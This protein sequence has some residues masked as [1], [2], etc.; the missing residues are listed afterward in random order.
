MANLKTKL[1]QLEQKAI[2]AMMNPHF[3]FNVI[4]AIQHFIN[5]GDKIAANK[6]LTDFAKLIRMSNRFSGRSMVLIEEEIAYLLL[7]LSF[8]KL[9]FGENLSYEIIVDPNIDISETR[10][11]VMMI[12]P[13]IENAIWHGILPLNAKGHLKLQIQRESDTLLKII[14]EDDGVGIPES[15]INKNYLEPFQEAQKPC[16][17][18]QRLQL[19][20]QS[21]GQKLYFHYKHL[22]PKRANKGTIAEFLLPVGVA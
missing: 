11:H 14:I 13:F 3:I 15:F 17:A 4:N 12:Q 18:I 9:R 6:Y 7:Y 19:L 10:I 20:A 16:I 8:E 21:S 1:P 5:T 22:H 2:Q